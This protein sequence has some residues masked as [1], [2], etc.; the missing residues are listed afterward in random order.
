MQAG[1]FDGAI[2]IGEAIL[3]AEP[4]NELVR[5]A[6]P[7]L[8]LRRDQLAVLKTMG[9]DADGGGEVDDEDDEGDEGDGAGAPS[10]DDEDDDDDDAEDEDGDTEDDDDDG[11]DDDG[12]GGNGGDAG[13]G[14]SEVAE[15]LRR[16]ELAEVELALSATRD[17]PIIGRLKKLLE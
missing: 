5:R 7:K 3:R 2:A 9:V 10:G 15:Q 6:M 1:D 17:Q 12:D 4:S 8:C 13:E 11:G 14:P 16:M